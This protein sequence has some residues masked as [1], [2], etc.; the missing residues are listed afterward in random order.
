[1]TR[2]LPG[3][4][5]TAIES[6]DVRPFFAVEL[7]FDNPNELYFWTGIGG[8]VFDGITY[9]GAGNLMQISEVQES[10]D[11]A[12]KGATLTLSGI[13]SD[14][15]ALAYDEPYQGRVC[16]IKFGMI[17]EGVE[18]GS[19]LLH[20]DD[21]YLLLND[22]GDK[23]DISSDGPASMFELFVGTMDQMNISEGPDTSTISLAVESK[24]IDLERPR[25]RR[26]TDPNQ[27]SRFS[28]DLAFEF[29]TRLQD[30]KLD[31]G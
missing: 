23:L 1:M 2:S 17:G 20:D 19:F 5:L 10:T 15:L 12:A 31:W 4:I 22:A 8:L 24:M 6:Q 13:P 25:I 30:E 29:V 16:K 11:I 28:G 7:L 3:D 26:Y 18:S 14:L 21:F 9:T 27:Q